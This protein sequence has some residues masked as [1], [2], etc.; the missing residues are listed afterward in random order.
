[1]GDANSSTRSGIF[2]YKPSE[3]A[4]LIMAVLF[5]ISAIWHLIVMIRKKTWF[6]SCLTVGAIMMTSGYIARYFSARSPLDL[7]PYIMQS[8]FIILPPSL[9]AATLYMIYGR[10]VLFVNAPEASMIPPARVTKVFVCGDVIAFFLQAGGGGMMAQASMANVGQKIMLLGL[11]TQLLFFGVF[12]VISL[13]FWKRMRSSPK[14]H[15]IPQHG[16]HTWRALLKMLLVSA[17]III[18]RCVFRIFEF[19]GGTKGSISTHEVYMYLFDAAPMFL[20]QLLF[21]FVHAGDVFPTHIAAS[22]FAD[23]GSYINLYPRV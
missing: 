14:S 9:Y 17:V 5:G 15:M 8:L 1:M 2:P 13:V 4:T 21:H 19:A 22:A 18:F 10:I 3:S 7:G 6:Y 23:D 11:F 20:V 16:K 12:L